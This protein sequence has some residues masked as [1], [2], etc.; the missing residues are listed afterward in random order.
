MSRAAAALTLSVL[1]AST[2]LGPATAWAQAPPKPAP[3]APVTAAYYYRVKWGFQDEFER[4]FLKNH[5]PVLKAEM[6][7]GGYGIV[8]QSGGYVWVESEVG[9]GTTFKIYLPRVDDIATRAQ[10]EKPGSLQRGAETV[11]LVEDEASLRGLLH[12]ALETNG[13]SVLVAR[14]GAEAV[15]IAEAHV[16]PI[17]IMV[18]DVIMPGL[19]GPQIVDLV[20]PI[21]PK[22][23]VLYISG[24]SGEPIT[25]HGLIGPGRAFLSKPFGPETLLRKVRESLDAG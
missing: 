23:R 8:K 9:M 5:Y 12:E 25:R 6:S 21:H 17:Q 24:Y 18:T 2:A 3:N 7:P 4:L 16:G 19:T 1:L 11:L 10:E 13:Y 20:A 15:Q 14:D 22:M